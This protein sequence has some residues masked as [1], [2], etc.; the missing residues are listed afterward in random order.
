MNLADLGR[1]H[2][3][4]IGG[5][6]MSGLARVLLARGVRVSGSD[7]KDSRRL[8]AVRALGA[9]VRVGHDP[10]GMCDEQGRCDVDT[11][12]Q[13]HPLQHH[14]AD[15]QLRFGLAGRFRGGLDRRT[16][17]LGQQTGKHLG[18]G[19]FASRLVRLADGRAGRCVG[20][21]LELDRTGID[22]G[23]GNQALN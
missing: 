23:H 6:G 21:Q 11:V 15:E 22:G 10:A 5:A 8:T 17:R 19:A 2:I 16:R 20:V 14:R 18:K 1:V 7:A 3:V 13:R 9:R 12:L 4:G